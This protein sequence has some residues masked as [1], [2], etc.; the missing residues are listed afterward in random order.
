MLR[1]IERSRTST[2]IK[3]KKDSR[4]NELIKKNVSLT[5]VKQGLSING[6][7]YMQSKVMITP[8]FLLAEVERASYDREQS[9]GL[10]HERTKVSN[11]ADQKEPREKANWISIW[12]K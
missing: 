3:K 1:Q 8:F 10:P 11:L 2:F 4:T 9:W 7:H 6:K 12:T 5:A